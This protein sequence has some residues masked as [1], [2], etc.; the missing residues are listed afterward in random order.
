MATNYLV[1]KPIYEA[2]KNEY[3]AIIIIIIR[4][5]YVKGCD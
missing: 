2:E 5:L 3:D 4:S 1:A